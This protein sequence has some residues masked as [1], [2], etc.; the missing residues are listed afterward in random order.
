MIEQA[1]AARVAAE[2]DDE[3]PLR[4]ARNLMSTAG[5]FLKPTLGG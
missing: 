4:R 5:A 3:T 2:E 1:K